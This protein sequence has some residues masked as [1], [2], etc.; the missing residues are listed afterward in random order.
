MLNGPY[1]VSVNREKLPSYCQGGKGR[2][3]GKNVGSSLLRRRRR[4]TQLSFG[5][6]NDDLPTCEHFERC[7]R[8]F[9]NSKVCNVH[10]YKEG[11][12]YLSH[13]AG[14]E[15]YPSIGGWTL[16]GSFPT[17]A[18]DVEKRRRFAKECVGLIEDY[19]FDGI[20]IG[21]LM[22]LFLLN[23]LLSLLFCSVLFLHMSDTHINYF[24]LISNDNI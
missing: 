18:D 12:I 6:V 22:M 21:E 24:L 8:N 13:V 16:S 17:V 23:L 4:R 5:D 15:I 7:H 2:D 10:R 3:D 9:P 20:D 14:A 11:L 19:G 1:E